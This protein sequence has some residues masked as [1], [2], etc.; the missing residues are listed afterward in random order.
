MVRF[1]PPLSLFAAIVAVGCATHADRV[2]DIRAAY[3]AGNTAEAKA[4]IDKAIDGNRREADVL[5]LDRATVLLTEGKS[6]EAEA[7]FREVRD[8]FDAKEGKDAAENVLATLSD[9]QQLAYAGED[10]EKVLIR[11]MLA[12]S[13][14][15]HDGSDAGAY[16]LQVNEKQQH[17]IAASKLTDGNG[18]NLRQNYKMV[19]AGAYLNAVLREE[20]QTNYDDAARSLEQVAQ[21]QPDFT[22]AKQD[23]ER[24]KTGHHSQ[25]GNGVVYVFALVGRGPY[26]VEKAEIVST[27]ALLIAD[28]MVSAMG[29]QSL[30]PTIAPIKVPVVTR[31]VN[32]IDSVMVQ[33]DGQPAGSTVTITDVGQMAAAQSE[34]LLPDTLARAVVRRVVKK[35][36]VFGV[37]EAAH[38][39]QTQ[40]LSLGL[41]AAGVIWEATESADT[42]CWGLLPDKIQVLRIELPAG[43][44]RLALQPTQG[45]RAVSVSAGGTLIGPGQVKV[46][47]ENGRNTY[48]LANF[49][50]KL[51]AGEIVTNKPAK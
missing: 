33:A 43:T 41:N 49:P 1:L 13:N 47:V 50:E 9:D 34:A 12:L 16:A 51:L 4:K 24:V 45:G 35:G 36:V 19:A 18:K 48:V 31:P 39:D 44:H 11:V 8:R 40:L 21:W 14:L 7:L 38:T 2:Q 10:Y 6:K 37:K 3:H 25:P 30:P 26:K 28:R 32:Y 23:L 46:Q 29:K 27:A 42:R 17:I 5:K 15:M 22:P 20:T